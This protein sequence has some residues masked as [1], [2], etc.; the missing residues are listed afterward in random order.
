LETNFRE[1]LLIENFD[2]NGRD[3][4]VRTVL[5]TAR[6]FDQ[7]NIVRMLL[8]D[9]NVDICSTSLLSEKSPLHFA[10][11]AGSRPTVLLFMTSHANV[12]ALDG[13]YAL[14]SIW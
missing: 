10:V 9:Y 1:Q 2:V 13:Q 12:N 3:I 5:I 6:I 11:I 7:S 14:L 8:H 4:F